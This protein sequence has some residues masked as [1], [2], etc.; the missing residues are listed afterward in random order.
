MIKFFE[1]L[2]KKSKP[3][4]NG[5]F[6]GFTCNTDDTINGF[7]ESGYYKYKDCFGTIH[8]QNKPFTKI[9]IKKIEIEAKANLD[10]LIDELTESSNKRILEKILNKKD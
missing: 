5:K 3:I 6:N 7:V 4:K 1:I 2:F 9:E 10:S 8:F